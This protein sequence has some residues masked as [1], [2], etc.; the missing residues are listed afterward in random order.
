MSS[1]GSEKAIKVLSGG[2]S[3]FIKQLRSSRLLCIILFSLILGGCGSSGISKIDTTAP[4][5]KSTSPADG[6]QAV[7]IDTV[8]TA[9]ISETPKAYTFTLRNSNNTP[10][11]G[12]AT[13]NGKVITFTPSHKLAYG[14]YTGGISVADS[15]G[16]VGT[17][18]FSFSTAPAEPMT[19]NTPVSGNP[20]VGKP[21]AIALLNSM[22]YI[23]YYNIT[24]GSLY[25]ISTSDGA[26]FSGPYLIA[27][28]AAVETVGSY[29]SLAISEN[30][31]KLHVAYYHEGIG[32]KHAVA[33]I[34][35]ISSWSL[36]TVDGDAGVGKHNSIAVDSNGNAHISYYDETNTALKYA[37]NSSGS[38]AA[39]VRDSGSS[40]DEP[41]QY[42]SI[43][44][45]TDNTVHI[46]Y[47][48]SFSKNLKYIN[49]NG[50]QAQG[51]DTT[52]DSGEYS[53][54]GLD[55]NGRVYIAY[56]AVAGDKRIVRIITNVSGEWKSSDIFEVID[57]TV[58]PPIMGLATMS[59][60]F[61]DTNNVV[62]LSYYGMDATT[63]KY[64]LYYISGVL[65]DATNSVW[66][67]SSPLVVD[68]T[69]IGFGNYVS[70]TAGIVSGSMKPRIAYY[71]ATAGDLK[72]AQ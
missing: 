5:I 6:A 7:S 45:A 25:M 43:K 51:F 61:I 3:M 12:T 41:G 55:S 34:S 20:D 56:N 46:S 32:L 26:T 71:D 54:L 24:N 21:N 14:T 52:A 59:P 8:L 40:G 27:G 64:F 72:F 15:A 28:P 1:S 29:S 39:S 33:D 53:S 13:I 23:S 19:V 62:N 35:D 70:I 44:I 30:T 48:D 38:W 18:S 57:F 9:T 50:W 2:L 63:T 16:N 69:G 65:D 47:Y 58:D 37:T 66:D 22:S 31:G 36:V 68:N 67:W 10:I 49:S 60:I 11:S 42:T 4:T 17:L